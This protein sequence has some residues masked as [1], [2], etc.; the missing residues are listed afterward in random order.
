VEDITAL[1]DGKLGKGLKG[2]L[3]DEV[4]NKGKGKESLLV[5]DS[6]LGRQLVHIPRV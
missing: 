5:V 1:Q 6:N 3:T 4:V 2:F